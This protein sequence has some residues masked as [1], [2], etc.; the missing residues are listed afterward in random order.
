M[1]KE[2][3][4][5]KRVLAW[6]AVCDGRLGKAIKYQDGYMSWCPLIVFERDYQPITGMS[7]GHAIAALKAGERV[8]RAGWNGKGMFLRLV[9]SIHDIPRAGT[10]HP[11]YRLTTEDEAT[12]LPWIGMKTADNK[13]VPW[14]AS[15]TDM[16]ADDWMIVGS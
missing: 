4:S 7:F 6:D 3:F 11:V 14:L 15:Q 1:T 5:T 13:F 10:A 2:Y 9:L 8:C 16:L 12:A